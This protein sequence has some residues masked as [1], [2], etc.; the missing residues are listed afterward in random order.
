MSKKSRSPRAGRKVKLNQKAMNLLQQAHDAFVAKFGREP[1]PSDPIF[2]DPDANTPQL[3]DPDEMQRA[4]TK[5]MG[6]A[7][8]R[9]E[10]IFAFQK[11]GLLLTEENESLA[12]PADRAAFDAAIDEY[13]ALE[14]AAAHSGPAH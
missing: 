2:F 14:N 6:E 3:L 12:S 5:A 1:G 11:T 7:G 9:P 8:I 4:M 13:F 10:I